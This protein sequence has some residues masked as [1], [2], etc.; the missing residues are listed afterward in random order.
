MQKHTAMEMLM[1]A[2]RSHKLFPEPKEKHVENTKIDA[3]A[4]QL[5]ETNCATTCETQS[6][7]TM[8]QKEDTTKTTEYMTQ[9]M[10]RSIQKNP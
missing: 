5:A 7:N 1:Q 10:S 6:A 3:N 2:F 4:Q 9:P 8:R